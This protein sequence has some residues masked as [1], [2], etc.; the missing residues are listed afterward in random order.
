VRAVAAT[1]TPVIPR[2]RDRSARGSVWIHENCAAVLMAWLPGEEGATAI[3]DVLTGE[4][5]PGGKLPISHPPN[6]G[7]DPG[8][9]RAQG[10]GGE[11]AS[12][13]LGFLPLAEGQ[14]P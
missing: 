11:V 2:P 9:L 12:T 7:A 6:G 4:I 3:V 10:L 13:A 8:P 1:G 5:N 14:Q